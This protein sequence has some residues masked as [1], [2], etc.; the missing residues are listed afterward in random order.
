MTNNK[1][2]EN[3][4]KGKWRPMM[5]WSYMIITLF[6][7][8]VAP[9]GWAYIQATQDGAVTQQWVPLTL[10]SGGLFHLAMGAILG[11]TA[12]SRGREKMMGVAGDAYPPMMGGFGG[13]AYSQEAEYEEQYPVNQSGERNG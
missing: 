2:K 4:I 8:I 5:A 6:D 7:F 13:A 11:V 10:G 1:E 9:A 12:W 3:W